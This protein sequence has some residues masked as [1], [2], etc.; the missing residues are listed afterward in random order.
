MLPNEKQIKQETF[1]QLSQKNKPLSNFANVFQF[2]RLDITLI[3][4]ILQTSSA[5]QTAD[6][7]VV[8]VT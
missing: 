2:F 8:A 4:P 7:K 6:I 3:I 5:K 1:A